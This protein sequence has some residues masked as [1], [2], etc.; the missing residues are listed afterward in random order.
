MPRLADAARGLF[1][2]IAIVAAGLSIASVLW[3]G[4]A[5]G[6]LGYDYA[7]C[8][9]IAARRALAGGPIYDLSFHRVG[10]EGLF[11]YPIPFL[12][13][14]L[15]FA[16]LLSPQS[17]SIAWI[18]MLL[19]A[20]AAAIALLPVRRDVRWLSLLL[21]GV[22][23]PVVYSLKLG[24]VGSLLFLVLVI[25]WR[26]LARERRL[27]VLIGLGT[28]IK[29]QPGLLLAWAALRRRTL[30]VLFGA[31][32][33][34]ALGAAAAAIVGL[35]QWADYVT[36]LRQLT[37]PIETPGSLAPAALAYRLGASYGLA[38]GVEVVTIAASLLILARITLRAPVD[39][40]FMAAIVVS[41]LI[42]PV[43]WDHYAI[44]L[45]LPVAWFL[46]RGLYAAALIPLALAWP[47]EPLA[48]AAVYPIAY[49]VTLLGLL[50]V[51]EQ[52]TTRPASATVA[53]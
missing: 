53:R 45:L 34:L 49:V 3:A 28:L 16:A 33:L 32:T 30:V 47:I 6:T 2:A 19:V 48:P 41:Q 15:P 10:P 31:A 25:A 23:W 51:G 29:L 26:N 4:H 17:A 1:P 27:G 42:S 14:V 37:N 40:S 35:G 5:S 50:V 36:L 9:D 21:A 22:S 39:V 18:G 7:C 8:Y 38:V 12:G 24:Q 44:L 13:I 46:D 11:D 43:L 20:F 52:G